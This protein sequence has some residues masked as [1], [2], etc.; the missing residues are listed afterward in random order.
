MELSNLT[1]Q[2]KIIGIIINNL[3]K[4]Q[5]IKLND[6]SAEL[7]VSPQFLSDIENG[8][9]SINRK[10][11]N[12]IFEKLQINYNWE[13][14]PFN[15]LPL[16]F[17][18]YIHIYVDVN[19]EKRIEYS[20]MII[21]NEKWRYSFYYP[22]VILTEFCTRALEDSDDDIN[23]LIKKC[24][25]LF[26]FF[27]ND[28]KAIFYYFKGLH[29]QLDLLKVDQAI[30][31][32]QKAIECS[33]FHEIN[34]M[35]YY[36][37]S[38]IYLKLFHYLHSFD[39]IN[40]AK[41][42]LTRHND[43]RRLVWCESIIGQIYAQIRYITKMEKQYL[44]ALLLAQTYGDKDNIDNICFNLTYGFMN[45]KEYKKA[46]YYGEKFLKENQY[47]LDLYYVLAWSHYQL[48]EIKDCKYYLQLIEDSNEE[49]SEEVQT[50]VT[51]LKYL[52]KSNFELYYKRLKK[53]YKTIKKSNN[54]FDKMIVLERIIEYCKEH[55]LYE[56]GF[57]YQQE[58]IQLTSYRSIED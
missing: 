21:E 19:E 46:I 43:F 57:H 29:Y 25:N 5:Q 9:K 56:E 7:Q 27:S 36:Q 30:Q 55:Q 15:E 3:R 38:V 48:N 17:E 10:M 16:L 20:K 50:Y 24:E 12:Q 35:V 14:D 4:E 32:Y 22:L 58:Y 34:A 13:I 52:L 54:N 39:C 47:K 1:Y 2:E 23:E 8:R 11:I 41:K 42:I 44:K 51:C 31:L 40:I 45:A 28:Q 33:P 37:L 53:F 6:L 26:E 18:T 49:L